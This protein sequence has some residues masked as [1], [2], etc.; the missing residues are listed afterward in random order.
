MTCVLIRDTQRNNTAEGGKGH[1]NTEATLGVMW[2]KAK[3]HLEPQ[4]GEKGKGWNLP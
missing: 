1:M 3:K 2:P 4:E